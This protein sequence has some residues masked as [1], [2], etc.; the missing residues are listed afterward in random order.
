MET[1]PVRIKR[2]NQAAYPLKYATYGDS[3]FDLVSVED[4][5]I[6]PG[7]TVAIPTGWAFEIPKG[8]E[9]QVRPRSGIS[10]KTFLR[11]ANTPGTV[12]SSYRGEVKVLIDNVAPFV[13]H[14]ARQVVNVE[15]RAEPFHGEVPYFTYRIKKGDRIAQGVITPVTQADF[16]EVE[17]LTNTQRGSRGFGSSGSS[18]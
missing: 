7:S 10:S 14:G 15:N 11:V 9:L 3:G 17:E 6:P 13:G 1:I 2:L 12:D 16:E 18:Y 5:I 8:Y 4:V